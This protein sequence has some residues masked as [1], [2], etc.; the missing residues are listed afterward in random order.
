M[1]REPK[2]E[3]ASYKIFPIF[4][5]PKCCVCHNTFGFESGYEVT[6]PVEIS[7]CKKCCGSQEKA[8]EILS[9]TKSNSRPKFSSQNALQVPIQ[10][11]SGNNTETN[12]N[13]IIRKEIKCD[14]SYLP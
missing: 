4:D 3:F 11:R 9:K 5:W 14:E 6:F 10:K 7:I 2:P 12:K 1:K 8:D 13:Y